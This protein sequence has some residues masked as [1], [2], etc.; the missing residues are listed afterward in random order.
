LELLL[1]GLYSWGSAHAE[2]FGVTVGEPLKKLASH[3]PGG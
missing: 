2:D 1:H 3:A